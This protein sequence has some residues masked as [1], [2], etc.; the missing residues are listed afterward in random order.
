MRKILLI[1]ATLLL[2]LA[3]CSNKEKAGTEVSKEQLDNLTDSGFPIVKDPLTLKMFA[4]KGANTLSNWDDILVFNTYEEMTGIHVEWEQVAGDALE[5]KRNLALAGGSLPDVFFAANLPTLDIY[6]YGQQGVFLKLNDMIDEHAPNLSRMLDENP[7]IKK[8]ITFPDGNIY[9]LPV[10]HDPNFIALKTG[11]ML[12]YHQ[13]VLDQVGM[14]I[15]ETTDQFYEYLKAVKEKT[16]YTPY[17]GHNM[18]TLADN[19]RGAFGVAT[20]GRAFIDKDP[21]SGDIRFY[22]T[23]EQYK[24]LLT[25]MFINYIV[26]N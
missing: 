11:P 6:K 19:L 13:D 4:A 23:T 7:D 3:A 21:A 10:I 17:G 9:S 18:A 26:K 5:E 1:M 8:A 24:E 25:N 14:D 16:D 12:Y 2:V 22:P 15:P 20:T